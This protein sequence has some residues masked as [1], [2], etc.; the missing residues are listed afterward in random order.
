MFQKDAKL[1]EIFIKPNHMT[2]CLQD[3]NKQTKRKITE[4]ET[5]STKEKQP[6]YSELPHK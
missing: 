3:Y 4:N 2:C 5:Y 1:L 6:E